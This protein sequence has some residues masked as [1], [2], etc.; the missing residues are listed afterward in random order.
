MNGRNNCGPAVDRSLRRMQLPSFRR[1][2]LWILSFL[3]VPF[4]LVLFS[5]WYCYYHFIILFFLLH[6]FFSDLP[7]VW[8]WGHKEEEGIAP[9]LRALLVGKV[10]PIVSIETRHDPPWPAVFCGLTQSINERSNRTGPLWRHSGRIWHFMSC[11][12]APFI[13]ITALP[14]TS[15]CR[16]IDWSIWTT[17]KR[18]VAPE[19]EVG[20]AGAGRGWGRDRPRG[21]KGAKICLKV[22]GLFVCSVCS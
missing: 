2:F 6:Y 17:G 11:T 18:S 13:C 14:S 19:A 1:S 9:W 4:V 7:V 20:E 12:D 8:P 15:M 22:A 10:A 3:V 5:F 21:R 16:P